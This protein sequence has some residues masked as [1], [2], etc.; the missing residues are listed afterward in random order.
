[1]SVGKSASDRIW[2]HLH[3]VR[4]LTSRLV[5]IARRARAESAPFVDNGAGE[6]SELQS[7]RRPWPGALS[8]SC[9]AAYSVG[10]ILIKQIAFHS[11]VTIR[12]FYAECPPMLSRE[13][14]RPEHSYAVDFGYSFW[15]LYSRYS[16]LG[17]RQ[18]LIRSVDL[19]AWSVAQHKFVQL[20][21]HLQVLLLPG[22]MACLPAGCWVWTPSAAAT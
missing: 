12:L 4:S 9:S 5:G 3:A 14:K 18:N 8:R 15:I 22:E 2:S 17:F 21:I 10:G 20:H 19:L 6:S 11:R 7:S 16:S 13:L 1:M